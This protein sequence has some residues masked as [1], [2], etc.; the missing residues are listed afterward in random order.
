MRACC[1]WALPQT[2]SVPSRR[3]APLQQFYNFAVPTSRGPGKRCGPRRIVGQSR[4]GAA[5]EEE[6]HH[7]GPTELRGPA[8][9]S[10]TDVFVARVQIRAVVEE[11]SGFLD[12]STACE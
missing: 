6:F 2:R 7:L 8:Q 11:P 1:G 9:R 10:G 4:L 12:V 3:P 5:A